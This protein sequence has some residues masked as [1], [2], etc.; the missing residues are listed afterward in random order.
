MTVEMDHSLGMLKVLFHNVFFHGCCLLMSNEPIEII[1]EAECLNSANPG[2]CSSSKC[3]TLS[4][5][6]FI[7]SSFTSSVSHAFFPYCHQDNFARML[8]QLGLLL[9]HLFSGSFQFLFI[10][11]FPVPSTCLHLP[12][13]LDCHH[14]GAYNV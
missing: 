13:P 4:C 11:V 3:L 6:S 1:G 14:K 12:Q 8:L 10:T 5:N 9:E 7:C 2:F